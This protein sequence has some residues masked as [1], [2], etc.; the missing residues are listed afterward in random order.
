MNPL[1]R[2]AMP[3]NGITVVLVMVG[4][5]GRRTCHNESS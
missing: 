5:T 4:T 3:R 1:E 2:D